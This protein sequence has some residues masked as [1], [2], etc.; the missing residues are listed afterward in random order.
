MVTP[1]VWAA[2]GMPYQGF[3]CVGCLEDRL[4]RRLRPRDFTSAMINDPSPWDT[5]RMADRK[6]GRSAGR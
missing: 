4:G 6:R 3:L 1:K 5:P 2:A